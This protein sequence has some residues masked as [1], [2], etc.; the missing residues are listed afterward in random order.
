MEF[1]T[2]SGREKKVPHAG[3]LELWSG[4]SFPQCGQNIF[5]LPGKQDSEVFAADAS[6]LEIRETPPLEARL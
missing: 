6:I 5:A 4:I 1:S 2:G 3:Q